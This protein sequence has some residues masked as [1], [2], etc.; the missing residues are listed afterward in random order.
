M[1]CLSFLEFPDDCIVGLFLS[2]FVIF[3]AI[4]KVGIILLLPSMYIGDVVDILILL[5]LFVD[6]W[7]YCYLLI[8][9]T[10]K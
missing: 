5:H 10:L 8:I 4:G 6:Y 3:I 9:I 7:D 1:I 2:S